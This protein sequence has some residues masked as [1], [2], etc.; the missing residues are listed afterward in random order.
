MALP[1]ARPAPFVMYPRAVSEPHPA[2]PGAAA[3]PGGDAAD[4]P[5]EPG[6]GLPDPTPLLHNLTQ[7][8]LEVIAGMRPVEH[9]ARWMSESAFRSIVVR[10]NL[11]ARARSARGVPATTSPLIVTTVRCTWP[12][13]DA[14][15]ATVIVA[16]RARTRAVAMRLEEFRGRWRAE[17]IALL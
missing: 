17:S 12:T 5:R 16:G 3:R 2:V 9:L 10:A 8:V 13:D 6:A 4:A 7:G 15:E 11:A 1:A 14:V